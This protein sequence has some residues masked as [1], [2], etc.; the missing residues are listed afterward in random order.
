[1]TNPRRRRLTP[2]IIETGIS[3]GH[4]LESFLAYIS[5]EVHLADN[6]LA[7]YR[8]DME[9]FFLWLGNRPLDRLNVN[10]LEG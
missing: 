7:A 8:R 1:M 5:S 10:L 4:W 3:H 6:T 9:R 2:K